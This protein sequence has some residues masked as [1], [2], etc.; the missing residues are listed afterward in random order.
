M[1][2]FIELFKPERH[3]GELQAQQGATSTLMLRRGKHW[4]TVVGDVP[5][6][7]LKLFAAA[8]EPRNP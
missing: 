8:V 7:T 2:L 1:S 5:V 6:S 4:I 3:R